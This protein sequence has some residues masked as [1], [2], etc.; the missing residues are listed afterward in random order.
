MDHTYTRLRAL[1]EACIDLPDGERE[2]WIEQHVQ[3]TGERI[4]L[5]LMLV[6]DRGES[7]FLILSQLSSS[8]AIA[9]LSCFCRSGETKLAAELLTRWAALLNSS[10]WRSVS[11]KRLDLSFPPAS[12]ARVETPNKLCP[13]LSTASRVCLTRAETS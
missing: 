5:E 11:A 2:R 10:N 3:D 6:A 12:K 13:I 8:L 7:G 1:F 4:E 9:S